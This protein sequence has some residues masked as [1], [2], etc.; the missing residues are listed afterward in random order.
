MNWLNV[1]VK[2]SDLQPWEHNPRTMTKK[3]AQRLLKSWRDLGQ[4]QT[5]A[6]GPSDNGS[7]CPVYDGHQR[8]SALLAAYG[9][10]YAIDARQSDRAL[11]EDERR[12]LI[13]QANLPVGAWNFETIAG[14]P[15]AQE[16]GFDQEMLHTWNGDASNL[17]QMMNADALPVDIE[18]EW[19]GMP[20]FE[21]ED[22]GA[23][24]SITVHF[25][26]PDNLQNFA[27]LVEQTITDKTRSIWY[28]KKEHENLMA[29][30]AHEQS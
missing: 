22:K 11:T 29:L 20:E 17:R 3:Q 28:P 13:T 16:W 19:A 26:S 2:L 14:W 10:N 5:I 21:Q 6:I 18:A 1:T 7:G 9:A 15:E 4:F 30:V 8:L 12:Y 25:D 27:E 24:K 23:W